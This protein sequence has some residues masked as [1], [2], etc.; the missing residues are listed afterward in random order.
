MAE[1]FKWFENED[2]KKLDI[3]KI[4]ELLSKLSSSRNSI[5]LSNFDLDW[6]NNF[7]ESEKELKNLIESID[8]KVLFI[9]DLLKAV[10]KIQNK[11]SYFDKAKNTAINFYNEM[12]NPDN[13]NAVDSYDE[14]DWESWSF[15]KDTVE[16]LNYWSDKLGILF[17]KIN[18]KDKKYLFGILKEWQLILNWS[19]DLNDKNIFIEV[20][21]LYIKLEDAIS[22]SYNWGKKQI[23]SVDKKNI[24]KLFSELIKLKDKY[25]I[26]ERWY[27]KEKAKKIAIN[28][29]SLKSFW[30]KEE[31]KNALD[32][33]NKIY[34]N[35]KD[36]NVI[37]KIATSEYDSINQLDDKYEIRLFQD[38]LIKKLIWENWFNDEYLKWF[39]KDERWNFI[40]N[41]NDFE[42]NSRWEDGK[43]INSMALANYFKYLQGNKQLNRQ[44]LLQTFGKETLISIWKIWK[45]DPSDENK[46]IAKK[47]LIDAWLESIVN[48]LIIFSD[49]ILDPR[50]SIPLLSKDYTPKK[51]DLNTNLLPQ[52][53][54]F[55]K[56]HSSWN[57][58]IFNIWEWKLNREECEQKLK[59]IV[60]L[61]KIYEIEQLWEEKFTTNFDKLLEIKFKKTKLSETQ[62]N[63]IKQKWQEKAKF[64]YKSWIEK[65]GNTDEA[66]WFILSE[67]IEKETNKFLKENE[68]KILSEEER[69]KLWLLIAET[70]LEK[71]KEELIQ[72]KEEKEKLEENKKGWKLSKEEVVKLEQINKEIVVL[73]KKVEK[74]KRIIITTQATN[75][76]REQF[77]KMIENWATKEEAFK[78]FEK[79]KQIN[80]Q[81]TVTTENQKTSEFNYF[82]SESDYIPS[83]S[84]W[85]NIQTPNW[86]INI[87]ENEKEI[88]RNNPDALK[89]LIIFHDFFKDLG[90]LSVWNLRDK[91]INWFWD[92]TINI[93][94]DTINKEE[95]IKF[96]NKL[97]DFINKAQN[98]FTKNSVETNL[99]W[100]KN[101]LRMFSWVRNYLNENKTVNLYWDDPFKALLRNNWVIKNELF[102][103]ENFIKILNN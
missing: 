75:K 61:T 25:S 46:Q 103:P 98:K 33:L 19:K 65:L 89:N 24:D 20:N 102:I 90:M 50:N 35:K 74:A 52:I 43:N 67:F 94:W 71:T 26:K 44:K 38:E 23:N 40:V 32:Y 2:L 29:K 8:N 99:W 39:N 95:L 4:E 96:W 3:D 73:E 69:I 57:C 92:V 31:A 21:E 62:K 28:Y 16:N 42:N 60:K 87:S 59:A 17:S 56:L 86:E 45:A 22:N 36:A 78:N 6:K 81:Q 83:N 37:D 66:C 84:W 91:I 88:T 51:E 5:D 58:W 63:L 48:E 72:K 47:I 85:F 18:K 93:D 30:S 12:N 64:I 14:Y 70:N 41:I 55:N 77:F 1:L 27:K 9:K 54:E 97:I 101:K 49:L 13:Q 15:Y 68:L 76:E 34:S 10:K 53:K 7:S 82:L 11:E 79:N 80:S 100:I